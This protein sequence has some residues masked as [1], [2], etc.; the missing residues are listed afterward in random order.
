LL[1]A[2]ALDQGDLGS[3]GVEP[4]GQRHHTAASTTNLRTL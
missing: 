3:A 2:L 1:D 4:D